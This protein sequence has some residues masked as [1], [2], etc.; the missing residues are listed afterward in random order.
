VRYTHLDQYVLRDN[1]FD[2]WVA[3]QLQRADI[4]YGWTHHALWS[5]KKAKRLGMVTVL[6]RANSHPL[7][8]SRLLEAEYQNEGFEPES[9]IL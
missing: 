2:Y 3:R 9:I 7:T 1:L 5:L 6:E 4:F 8:Y